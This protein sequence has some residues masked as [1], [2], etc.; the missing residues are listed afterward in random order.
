MSIN[1]DPPVTIPKKGFGLSFMDAQYVV[2]TTLLKML[3]D[4]PQAP[5]YMYSLVLKWAP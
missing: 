2:E 5:K 4:T 3:N 1:V